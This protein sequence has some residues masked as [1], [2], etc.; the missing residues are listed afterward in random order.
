V[1]PQFKNLVLIASL[2]AIV[3]SASANARVFEDPTGAGIIISNRAEAIYEDEAGERFTTVSP[4][5]TITVLAVATIA[6]TPDETAPSDTIAPR[7]SVT[8][9]FR[10]CNT[11]NN[12]DTFTLTR[13]DVTA[14]AVLNS[15]YF[16]NDGSGTLSDGD[17]P[18]RVNESI[19]PQLAPLKCIGVLAVIDTNDAP[20]QS[21]LTINLVAR[22]NALNAVNGRGEDA[23][24][25][26]N[27]VGQGARL[28]DPADSNREPSKFVNGVGQA[29]VSTGS[30]FT[31]TI[32]FRNSGD[33]IARNIVLDD[34]LTPGIEYVPASLQVNDRAV[35]DA[36]DG[37]EGSVQGANIKFVFA[38]VN[39][40]EAFRITFRARLTAT[41]I[42]GTGFVNS[43]SFTGDNILPVKTG[44]ATVVANP[45]G[46]VFAGRA[47]SSTPI[48]G[49]RVEV[50][51]DQKSENFVH[52]PADAGFT[53]NEKNENPFA[54]DG[55][56]RF[57]FALSPDEIGSANTT[58]DYFMKVT[59]QGYITRMVQ[60]SLRPTQAGLFALNVHAVDSQPLASAG[61]FD[62]VREDVRINDLA[63]LVLNIPM[64]E[65][66][67]LQIVK[68]ADRA[69]AEIGDT[70]TYRVEVHNPTAANVNDVVVK[71][72]LPPSFH[73]ANGSAL[74]TLGAGSGKS[75]EPEIQANELTF[76]I[77]EILHGATAQLLYRVRVGANA[78]EGD[79]ENLATAFAVFPSG[80]HVQSAPARAVVYVSAGVFSTRQVLV[81]RVFVD[82][83]GNG[84]FDESDRPVPG[85]RLYLSNGQSVI[86]DSAG[87]YNF[88]SLGDGSQAISLDPVSVPKHYALTDGGR[89]SGKSWARLLRTPIGG[90]ALLRQNFILIDT[91]KPQS[92]SQRNQ[93]GD[94]T[95]QTLATAESAPLPE[96]LIKRDETADPQVTPTPNSTVSAKAPEPG[97]ATPGTYEIASTETVAAVAPGEVRILSPASNS[98]SMS[99]GLQAQVRVAL[100]WTVKLEINGAPVSDNNI[101]VRSLDHKN[102][103]STFTFVGLNLKPGPNRIRCTAVSP[104]GAPGRAEEIT[105]VGRGPA[106]R[107]QIVSE[108]SEIQSGGGDSTIVRVK[109]FDQWG[110]PALDGQVGVET[111]L[112]QLR[113]ATDKSDKPEAQPALLPTISTLQ[114]DAA[115]P[116]S[117][118]LDQQQPNQAGGQVVV[119]LEG[120]EA[121]LKLTGSGTPGQARLHAQTGEIE[122][123]EQVRII[124]EMRPTILV[125]FAEMSFGKSIP[126]VGLRDEQG[127]FRRRLSFFYSGQIPGNNMLTLSYDTQRPIN[128]TAGR[129]RIFQLDPLDRVY[130]LFGDSSTRY[131]AAQSN[132]KLY[133][134]LDHKRSYAMFG[135]F[136]A[137]MEAPLAGYARK[138]TGVKA[139]LENS[140]GDFITVTGA[141]PDTAFARDVFP[142][143]AL[144]ILQL[145]NGEILTGSETVLL[146]VR[147]RRNPEV[148]IS[149]ETLARSVDYNLDAATGRMFFMRYISTF[150]SALNL[151]QVIVT[152][153]H[154]AAS[155]SSAVYTA[156][157]HKNFKG[158]GLKLGLSAVLQRQPDE[159]NFLL[160]GFD[161]EKT[162]PRG[163]S[164]QVAWAGSQGAVV[165]GGNAIGTDNTTHDGMAYQLTLAQPLPFYGATVRARLIN[166]SAGFFNPFGGTVTPGSRRGEVSLEMK[167]RANSTLHFG[168]TSER[169]QTAN[170]D[171]GRLTYSAAWDQILNER[172]KFHLG[173]DHRSFT[174]DLNDKRTDS[175]LITA[176]ADVQVTDKLQLSVKREQNLN[177]ADP[178]YPT[179]TT[180][181]ATYQIN[182]LTKL[183]FSQRLAAAPITPI[184]DYSGTGFAAVSSRRE[185]AFGVETRFGKYTSMTGR[186]QLENGINGT[187]SF[188]VLGL[189]DRLPLTKELSLELGFERGFHLTGPNKSFNSAAFGFGWQPNSDFRASAHYEYRDRGGVGQVIAAGAAGKLRE[190]ITALARIQ[191]SRGAFGGKSN[192]S[193]EGSAAL[194]IRPLK[195]DRVGVLFSYTHHS[196][197][198]DATAATPTKD[199]LDSLSVDGYNQITKRLELYGRFALR[200]SA[201]GQP[202]LPFVSTLSFLTQARAQY[203]VTRRLDWAFETRLLFQ[204]SSSTMRSVYATE[205]GFWVLPDM[206]LGMGYNFTSAKEPAGSQVLPT[207][208]GFYFTISSK[209]S[210]LFDLFGTAKAGLA[211]STSDRDK[212]KEKTP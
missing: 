5:V 103:V 127:Q 78:R 147:D 51:T 75:I 92:A 169:N 122:A 11:G 125:G 76:R 50:I 70:I 19:S 38:R 95:S 45:F 121:V 18:A 149:H 34:Q 71:D 110:N 156:R 120:G 68:S 211:P 29:V 40:G 57:S 62:L 3:L 58:A 99:V 193:L 107:L 182:A 145:S 174:D 24:T 124:S 31:Y 144:G 131:E 183:F 89:V 177:D 190:G 77:S 137:D 116:L 6:V 20:P 69:R 97:M 141:R 52:L 105:V 185:T 162:L 96:S 100:N 143:G 101:G 176:G 67:G 202:Q 36:L 199:R 139:H 28:T 209:L 73:Y 112:G 74:L 142:A 63:A 111:S 171:N 2:I 153:E 8:R 157:A 65:P 186:Y 87:L 151:T 155:L 108:K 94:V 1:K 206:R 170:V 41:A 148:I 48:A 210:N 12:T 189:Q 132:S 201:N 118:Q 164:L 168:V 7:D 106:R 59:A 207:R 212:S 160:G 133:A 191:W 188:A 205:A 175:N 13:V 192:S 83:N 22:S 152:Y 98:V 135:D 130:P 27:A 61:G 9:V 167:P 136:E 64:F 113:R 53:P 187:D 115:K 119:Q 114:S 39:P 126:E 33:T 43:A 200:F 14:P 81:G 80:E 54:S 196:V 82:T 72:L 184:G 150:D 21:T 180:L 194:A 49:A 60:L 109:A 154:R 90:G 44:T 178:T 30:Q 23:G 159:G 66:A 181:G 104:N 79:Q 91:H 204:P 158:I 195:S 138:L 17:A 123:N 93:E 32:S 203:L 56:G 166:A 117:N 102:Q 134:R 42:G 10:V 4:T 85:A 88:P 165:G 140:Q 161:A 16:D 46:L 208:R 179:Q 198:Q 26:I 55:Q 25:I 129:D 84:Q 37:D 86:T 197:I 35:S 146:E 47:G 173:F 163:G 128:R 15:L 172:I